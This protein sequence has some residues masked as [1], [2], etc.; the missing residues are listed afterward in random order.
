MQGL[1]KITLGLE[2][3]PRAKEK[4]TLGLRREE[5]DLRRITLGLGGKARA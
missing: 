4:L 5:Q 3:C 2:R 1:G